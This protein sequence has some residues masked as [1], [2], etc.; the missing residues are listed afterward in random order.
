MPDAEHRQRTVSYFL[1]GEGRQELESKFGCRVNL[2]RRLCRG[3]KQHA[4]P[5]YLLSFI[6]LTFLA[7]AGVFRIV[8]PG[9]HW[10]WFLFAVI[11]VGLV[12]SRSAISILNWFVTIVM[13]PQVC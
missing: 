2:W 6:V 1:T 13:P 5:L 4:L 8:G 10:V 7:T 11:T 12:A 9:P 3:L